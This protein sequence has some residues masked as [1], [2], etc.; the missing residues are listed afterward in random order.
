MDTN[1]SIEVWNNRIQ[2][3]QNNSDVLTNII[4]NI[5]NTSE[6]IKKRIGKQHNKIPNLILAVITPHRNVLI[7]K[8]TLETFLA[9]LQRSTIF[10]YLQLIV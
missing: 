2:K 7:S 8:F 9:Y 3:Q 5:K 6:N 1:N 10:N 4:E